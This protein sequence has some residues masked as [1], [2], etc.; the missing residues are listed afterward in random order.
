MLSFQAPALYQ[1]PKCFVAH[2]IMP[3]LDPNQPPSKG[4]LW[5][6]F[7]GQD[8]ISRVDLIIP[9]DVFELVQAK[10]LQDEAIPKFTRIVMSLQDV[11]SADFLTK[12]VKEGNVSMLSEG[13]LGIDNVFTLRKGV[14]TMY[15]DRETYERA[16]LVGKP[17]G[18]KGKRGLK[19][20]WIVEIDLTASSMVPGKKGFDRIIY[21]SKNALN[22]QLTWLMCN[23]S[24]TVPV[25]DLLQKHSPTNIKANVRINQDIN[26][27]VPGL[28][29]PI[30]TDPS[31]KDDFEYFTTDLYEWLSLV[32]MQSPRILAN[33]QIDPYLSRYQVPEGSQ[34]AKLCKVSWQG[35]FSSSWSHKTLMDM[36]TVLPPKTWFS[37]STSTFP[38]GLAGDNSECTVLRIPNT[39]G[40][41]L[42]WE[43]KSH[44]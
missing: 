17:H 35:F 38:K 23:S 22:Q 16:G 32:R 15:L 30:T 20:R 21:A 27:K 42:L 3:H 18:V 34:N 6:T 31:A 4:K 37:F 29:P 40:E 24:S 11:L 13:R 1:T 25:D 33:D 9:Q 2:G 12:Y 14:L 39:R 44:E 41:F 10:L 5:A 26:A 7:L 28:A 43:V 36:I 8:F 19:P